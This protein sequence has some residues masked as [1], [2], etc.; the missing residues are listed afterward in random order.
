[1]PS[2]EDICYIV[3]MKRVVIIDNYDSFTYNL[4]QA[5][6]ILSGGPEIRV[7]RNDA[8]RGEDLERY[9]PT[10]L[11]FSP[12]PCTPKEAGNSSEII[13]FWAGK[14]AILGVCL[15][16]QC[17]AEAFGGKIL[18][19]KRC[20]HGKTSQIHH[21]GKTIY[22][23][24]EN[25][26]TAMRYHSLIVEPAQINGD[27]KVTATSEQDEI[28]GIRNEKLKIEGVQFHPESFG[29]PAGAKLLQN[30]LHM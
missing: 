26:F 5:V 21:D 15:G 2:F 11:I 20:M 30:F 10:H 22:A 9:Q 23:G 4:V 19:A 13:H 27:F 6:A 12:G 16:H 18:R 25:P 1:M 28:M 7:Y 17:I 14:A 29:T 8:I 3:V 24:I